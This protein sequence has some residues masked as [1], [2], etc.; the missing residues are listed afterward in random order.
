MFIGHYAVALAVAALVRRPRLGPLALA[1]QLPDVALFL[2]AA[3]G[4]EKLGVTPGLTAVSALDLWDTRWT[5]S[6][7]GTLGW[8]AGFSA[9]VKWW[10]RDARAAWI[11]GGVVASHWFLD[12]VVHP[13]DLTLVGAGVRHGW[14]LYDHPLAAMPLEL[15]IAFVAFVF[16]LDRTRATDW[17]GRATPVLFAIAAIGFQL[18]DWLQPEP[19]VQLLRLP[20]GEALRHVAVLAIL[21]VLAWWV[22]DTR[23]AAAKTGTG[24][25]AA[26][27]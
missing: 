16:Y 6:L 22:G 13:P 4:I 15:M 2:L 8:A 27:S 1:A 21:S 7:L 5:H 18:W 25:V 19:A 17:R 9:A 3:A 12:L 23:A 26:R 20:A 11:G 10:T 24:A 14:G